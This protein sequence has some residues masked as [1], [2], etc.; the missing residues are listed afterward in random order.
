[1][2]RVSQ[3]LCITITTSTSMPHSLCSVEVGDSAL[4]QTRKLNL[5][6]IQYIN[7]VNQNTSKYNFQN[8]IM[9]L[10]AAP[11]TTTN[12]SIGWCI[13]EEA[14]AECSVCGPGAPDDSGSSPHTTTSWQ[15]LVIS[16]L[17]KSVHILCWRPLG[18]PDFSETL[19]RGSSVVLESSMSQAKMAPL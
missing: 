17:P 13:S 6:P 15:F 8:H 2:D 12:L 18:N 11:A 7:L 5:R 10:M 19:Q 4:K 3:W 16:K 9:L 1:M 14:V